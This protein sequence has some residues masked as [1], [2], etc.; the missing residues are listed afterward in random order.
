MVHLADYSISITYMPRETKTSVWL[1]LWWCLLYCS[2]L[3]PN[4]K[5]LWDM[6]VNRGRKIYHAKAMAPHSSALAWKIPGTGEPAGLRSMGSLRVGH[7][8]ATSLSLSLSCIGEENGNPLQC[9]CLENPRDGGA[10]WAAIY[11]VVQTRTR[12]KRLS[13]SSEMSR[14]RKYLPWDLSYM[15][16]QKKINKTEATL[17]EQAGARGRVG[18]E[19]QV[20]NLFFSM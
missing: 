15:C 11:G 2:G 3:K 20:G 19:R 10:W 7:D 14:Q 6:P 8:W 5:Y 9:S 18:V 17:R 13:S 1:A 4:P 16:D 12:L